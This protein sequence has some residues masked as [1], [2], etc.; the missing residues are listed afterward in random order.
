MELSALQLDHFLTNGYLII[1][2]FFTPSICE[3]LIDRINFIINDYQQELPVTVFTSET[4]DHAKTEYFLNSGDKIRF[5]FEPEAFNQQ[6][7]MI[8]PLE[9]S[10]N[11]IGH[12]L[13]E[14]DPIFKL[15]SRSERLKTIC[16]QLG[17][18]VP[19]LIQSMYI[20]KQPGIGAEVSCHQDATFLHG[21][22]DVLGFWFALEDATLENGCLQVMPSPTI[23]PLSRKMIRDNERIYFEDYYPLLWD[24]KYS[25]PLEV[26]QGSLIV[27]H[28]R[29]PHRS[30]ANHSVKSRHAYSLHALD[31]AY[32]Y[33]ESNWLRMPKGLPVW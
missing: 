29:L 17:F 21:Q 31:A 13:H 9:K 6:G 30:N 3:T 33:P 10:L 8:R 27:I 26:K 22:K 15:Y 5:F 14:L 25:L 24:D 28:G 12:A 4:Q 32:P 2:K 7:N 16:H 23:I 20:F 1:E 18:E 11:K 19:S